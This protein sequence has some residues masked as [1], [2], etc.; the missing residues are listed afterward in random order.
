MFGAYALDPPRDDFDEVSES[1]A[2][3]REDLVT[4]EEPFA[5]LHRFAGRGLVLADALAALVRSLERYDGAIAA[6][7][8]DAA[9][10]QAAAVQTNA[11]SAADQ[12][13]FFQQFAPQVN[14]AWDSTLTEAAI[15]WNSVTVDQAHQAFVDVWGDPP[16]SPSEPMQ[17]FLASVEGLSSETLSPDGQHP[18]LDAGEV[19]TRPDTLLTEEFLQELSDTSTQLRQL[20]A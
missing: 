2:T 6:E 7:D 16:D 13:D 8:A 19:P 20:V 1:G 15:D 12:L 4:D 17:E 14:A 3:F 18:I 5:S 9:S 10:T 11:I